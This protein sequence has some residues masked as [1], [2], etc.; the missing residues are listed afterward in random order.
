M[1]DDQTTEQVRRGRDD[2]AEELVAENLRL[3][4]ELLVARDTI[5]GQE[6]R[7]GEALGEVRR[8]E[9]ELVRYRDSMEELERI[10]RSPLGKARR[11]LRALRALSRRPG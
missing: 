6:A 2:A 4:E 8:L 10:E 11:V 9:A 7:L 3:K 1:Q 5:V